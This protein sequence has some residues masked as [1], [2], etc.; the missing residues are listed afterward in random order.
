MNFKV[1]VCSRYSDAKDV[2]GC[3]SESESGTVSDVPLAVMLN[4]VTYVTSEACESVNF[5]VS[6]FQEGT[7]KCAMKTEKIFAKEIQV[8]ANVLAHSETIMHS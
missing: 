4:Y 7:I 8:R 5:N 1:D 2:A 3:R 6:I